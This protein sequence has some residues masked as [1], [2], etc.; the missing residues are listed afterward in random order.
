MGQQWRRTT[1][2]SSAGEPP[3][4]TPVGRPDDHL[5]VVD[6]SADVQRVIWAQHA[7]D[8][9]PSFAPLGTWTFLPLWWWKE[10]ALAALAFWA[11]RWW[12]VRRRVR[13]KSRRAGR[14]QP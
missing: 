8:G 3:E 13:R 4:F 1:P 10:I 9:S 2:L 11:A 7:I 5:V 6:P 12:L 14:S